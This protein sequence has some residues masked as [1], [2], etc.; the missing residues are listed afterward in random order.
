[1]ESNYIKSLQI[2]V[3]QHPEWDEDRV[4]EEMKKIYKHSKDTVYR[5]KNNNILIVPAEDNRPIKV[6]YEGDFYE[7]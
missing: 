5:F 1:M 2:R 6:I 3:A 7:K 4:W